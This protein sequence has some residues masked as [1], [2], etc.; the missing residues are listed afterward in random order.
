MRVNRNGYFPIDSSSSIDNPLA[1]KGPRASIKR[2]LAELSLEIPPHLVSAQDVSPRLIRKLAFTVEQIWDEQQEVVENVCEGRSLATLFWQKSTRTRISFEAMMVKLRGGS[3][4]FAEPS[5][6]R[7]DLE[8]F[9]DIIAFTSQ[10]VDLIVLRHPEVGAAQKAANIS[11]VPIINAGD[12]LEHPSQAIIDVITIILLLGDPKALFVGLV[13]DPAIRVFR[14]LI[15]LLAKMKVRSLLIFSPGISKL[16]PELS[17]ELALNGVSC[18]F[19]DSILELLDSCDIVESVGTR[20][21]GLLASQGTSS[22]EE[23]TSQ[24]FRITVDKLSKSKKSPILLHPGPLSDS[25]E[26]EIWSMPCAK[27]LYQARVG[28]LV[29]LLLLASYLQPL[30][31]KNVI[32]M[33]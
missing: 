19:V 12:G 28:G 20:Y 16:D 33:E 23:C 17:H 14:S 27:W 26:R 22:N 7:G 1:E 6:C 11:S 32:S 2:Q 24:E 31:D 4:G 10:T 3:T 13:G 5:V 25:I 21:S 18:V 15:C 9:E 29:R 8:P 30:E